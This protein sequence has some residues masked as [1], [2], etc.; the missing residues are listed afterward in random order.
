MSKKIIV[1]IA[2]DLQVIMDKLHLRSNDAMLH[3][4]ALIPL[5]NEKKDRNGNYQFIIDLGNEK[6]VK[7][8]EIFKIEEK[9]SIHNL[10]NKSYL[11]EY[12]F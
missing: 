2:I 9:E 6:I 1:K 12:K 4:M 11:N 8:V 10:E 3:S 7:G 5:L